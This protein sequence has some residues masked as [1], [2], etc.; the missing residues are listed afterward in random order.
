M[1]KNAFIPTLILLFACHTS[2]PSKIEQASN[3]SVNLPAQNIELINA[4][5]FR[6]HWSDYISL[7]LSKCEKVMYGGFKR[8]EFTFEND[9][10]Y[11]IDS[12]SVRVNYLEDKN[13]LYKTG[14]A[15]AIDIEQG[16]IV[17]LD[18]PFSLRGDTLKYA[19]DYLKV[20]E[21]KLDYKQKG[22]KKEI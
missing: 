20:R 18:A 6:K 16:E 21:A 19:I 15:T 13:K 17:I 3:I 1:Y 11:V 10:P 22:F 7:K 8:V 12:I 5:M 4:E 14:F 2:E 9:S